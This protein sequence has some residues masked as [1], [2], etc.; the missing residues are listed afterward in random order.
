[1]NR[2]LLAM[3]AV[4]LLAGPMAAKAVPIVW[5]LD[6][7][8]VQGVTAGGSFVFDAD[9]QLFS[10]ILLTTSAGRTYTQFA[11]EASGGP[12]AG[13]I[14]LQ[15]GVSSG[16]TIALNLQSIFLNLLTNAGGVL[17]INVGNAASF[18][19]FNCTAIS[20]CASGSGGSV[21]NWAPRVSTLT[22]TPLSV[23]EPS[24]LALFGLGLV[25]LGFARRRRATN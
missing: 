11:G 17:P 3:I 7:T 10:D 22:G 15:Q 2:N 23:P 14:F 16:A 24:T 5:A 20:G 1:M 25:G 21:N 12:I 9:T 19:E 4:A 18:A 8:T 13:L 6:G